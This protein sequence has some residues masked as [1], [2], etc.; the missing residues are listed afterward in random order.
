MTT[1]TAL[2]TGITGQER[3]VPAELLLKKGSIVDGNRG[4]A[5]DDVEVHG[6]LLLRPNPAE[7]AVITTGR[8]VMARRFIELAAALQ[9]LK[10]Q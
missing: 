2:I 8:Q 9:A 6:P 10:A 5:R 1:P 3:R 4:H 7:D